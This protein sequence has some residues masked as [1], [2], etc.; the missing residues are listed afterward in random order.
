MKLRPIKTANTMV[1]L[2]SMMIRGFVVTGC[3]IHLPPLPAASD[4]A[5]AEIIGIFVGPATCRRPSSDVAA[6][7][8]GCTDKFS[9][10]SWCIRFIPSAS[11]NPPHSPAMRPVRFLGRTKILHQSDRLHFISAS[12]RNIIRRHTA[13]FS[14]HATPLNPQ[15]HKKRYAMFSIYTIL[16]FMS[17]L[18]FFTSFRT[19]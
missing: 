14:V 7:I 5:D 10:S 3:P 4:Y 11:T 13:V 2:I 12:P 18:L 19:K 1:M 17:I 16:P 8:Y 6:V 9:P 15:R